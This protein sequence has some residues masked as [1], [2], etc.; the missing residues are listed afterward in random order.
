MSQV[1]CGPDVDLDAIDYNLRW[2][3]SCELCNKS[4]ANRTH[5]QKHQ[6]EAHPEFLCSIC[7]KT[8]SSQKNLLAHLKI[9]HKLQ[10]TLPTRR[11]RRPNFLCSVC[12]KT[13]ASKNTLG[14][15]MKKSHP[16]WISTHGLHHMYDWYINSIVNIM[17]HLTKKIFFTEESSVKTKL[18]EW[19]VISLAS[20]VW[21][22]TP[23]VI[24]KV[25]LNTIPKQRRVSSFRN[26][27]NVY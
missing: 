12:G 9:W 3:N 11:I 13:Y 27:S 26:E 21:V 22:M 14:V 1:Y 25:T 18:E 7:R 2:L 10:V 20:N 8:Y 24:D 19:G 6:R 23:L 5:L 4:Y 15:H 16:H 17:W